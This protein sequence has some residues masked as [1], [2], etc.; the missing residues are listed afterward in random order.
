MMAMPK[1]KKD[2]NGEVINALMPGT[3]A[4]LDGTSASAASGVFDANADTI[5]RVSA[6]GNVRVQVGATPTALATSMAMAAGTVEYFRI[7]AGCKVAVLGGKATVTV[8]A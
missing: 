8:M 1:F 2:L 5:V 6:V 4:E 3:N 7:L